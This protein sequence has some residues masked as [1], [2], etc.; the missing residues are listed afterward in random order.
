[1]LRKESDVVP[2]GNGPVPQQEEFDSGQPAL[3]D[4]IR[5]LYERMDSRSDRQEKMLDEI[6]VKMTRGT[7]Q[8]AA[9]LEHDARQPHFAMEADG[10]ANTKTRERTEGAA[11]AVQAMHGDSCTAQKV[12]GRP[13]T[14]TSFGMKAELP[15]FPCRDDVQVEN[16]DSWPKSCLSSVNMRKPTPAGGLLHA[17]SASTNKAQGT[18]FPPHLLPW[19]FLETSEEDNIG[20]TRQTFA[21][22]NRS[23]HPKVIETKSRQNL[24]FDPSG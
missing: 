22:Y 19:N 12:Q 16:D 2:E 6:I 15:A 18:N 14:S 17:G 10:L 5:M 3:V 23:W 13:K 9:S 11:T 7:S 21:K 4:A 1:M 24:V 20:T 8:C